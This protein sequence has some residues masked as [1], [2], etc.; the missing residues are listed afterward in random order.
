MKL[1]DILVIPS[2]SH[3]EW[4]EKKMREVFS[5]ETFLS[6]LFPM[7]F[8]LSVTFSVLLW[9]LPYQSTLLNI[10]WVAAIQPF[11]LISGHGAYCIISVLTFLSEIDSYPIKVPFYRRNHPSIESISFFYSYATS[12]AVIFYLWLLLET[13][14]GPF[15]FITQPIIV[16][17]L[18]I[19]GFFPLSMFV[20][21]FLKVNT[22][23]RRIKQSHIDVINQEVIVALDKLKKKPSKENAETLSQIMDIQHRIERE[24]VVFIKIEQ[25][26]TFISTLIAPFG[27]SIISFLKRLFP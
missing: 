19:I 26:L 21:S 27:Q 15:G 11:L 25:I 8:A 17:W 10:L 3:N 13:P 22:F 23:T 4:V 14:L 16:I 2:K 20:W 5:F 9:F 18:I 7:L 6:K 12:V 24:N 1:E